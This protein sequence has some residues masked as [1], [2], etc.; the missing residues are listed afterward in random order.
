[1]SYLHDENS[2]LGAQ[3]LAQSTCDAAL[4]I[5]YLGGVISLGIE[6]LRHL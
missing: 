2:E 1:M 4:S 3:H 6:K 5:Q